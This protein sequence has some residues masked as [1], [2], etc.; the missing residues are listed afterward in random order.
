MLAL[1]VELIREYPSMLNVF[2]VDVYPM[3]EIHTHPFFFNV[4]ILLQGHLATGTGWA[5]WMNARPAP[6]ARR[7]IWTGTPR[8]P[9]N[10]ETGEGKGDMHENAR[11]QEHLLARIYIHV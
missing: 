4:L 2:S 11:T 9:E 8:P 7:V 3:N 10:P 5:T 1:N 6:M